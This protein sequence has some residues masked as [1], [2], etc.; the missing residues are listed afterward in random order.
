MDRRE[1]FLNAAKASGVVLPSWGLLPLPAKGQ[2]QIAP[3][4]LIYMHFDGGPTNDFFTDPSV[5][6][7]YNLYTQQGLAIPGAGNLRF[8][9]MGLNQAFFGRFFEQMPGGK[10]GHHTVE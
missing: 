3:K 10:R 1:F 5:N 8:A 4:I 7:R 6:A 9:P 2:T